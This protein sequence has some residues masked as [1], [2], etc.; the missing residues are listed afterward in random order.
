[1]LLSLGSGEGCRGGRRRTEVSEL[2]LAFI[3]LP[4]VAD[5]QKAALEAF[6]TLRGEVPQTST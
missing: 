3:A 1:V 5:A 6:L 2:G 4:V